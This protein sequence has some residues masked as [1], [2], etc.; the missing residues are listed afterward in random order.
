M[1]KVERCGCEMV[2]CESDTGHSQGVKFESS[3]CRYP[4]AVEEI[5]AEF[6]TKVVAQ[7]RRSPDG[8]IDGY[9]EAYGSGLEFALRA[10]GV[11]E[12]EKT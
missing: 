10:L 2:Y 3:A 11:K 1:P 4:K 5:R 7:K 6:T 9:L 8:R 12:G